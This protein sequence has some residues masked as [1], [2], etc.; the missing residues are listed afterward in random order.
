MNV[1]E[2]EIQQRRESRT[3]REAWGD[4][5]SVGFIAGFSLMGII[6]MIVYVIMR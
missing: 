1:H 5:Y 4:G 6:F 2:K 3:V